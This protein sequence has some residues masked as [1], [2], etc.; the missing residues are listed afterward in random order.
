MRSN[1]ACSSVFNTSQWV[2]RKR[3]KIKS[4]SSMPRRQR[5]TNLAFCSIVV[6]KAH[7]VV[8]NKLSMVHRGVY[9]KQ[10]KAQ[11]ARQIPNKPS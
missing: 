9:M 8:T 4:N 7:G 6:M 3:V 1:T 5:H 11:T 2:S 10:G